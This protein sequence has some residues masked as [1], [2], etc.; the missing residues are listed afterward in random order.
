MQMWIRSNGV[1]TTAGV[2][3]GKFFSLQPKRGNY[4]SFYPVFMLFS[5]F[6]LTPFHSYSPQPSFFISKPDHFVQSAGSDTLKTDPQYLYTCLAL[7]CSLKV[8]RSCVLAVNTFSLA[9]TTG[10]AGI[11]NI[12]VMAIYITQKGFV[13]VSV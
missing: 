9:Q 5:P 2:Y 7:W 12:T 11:L 6:S 13:R 1:K 8:S 4:K 3:K 10:E